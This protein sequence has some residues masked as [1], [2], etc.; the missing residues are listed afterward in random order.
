MRAIVCSWRT[1]PSCVLH[2]SPSGAL[3]GS[4]EQLSKR[5]KEGEGGRGDEYKLGDS[6]NAPE[7]VMIAT[8]SEDA[9]VKLW[10]AVDQRCIRTREEEMRERVLQTSCG[11][12]RGKRERD[13]REGRERDE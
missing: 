12:E 4:T 10:D 11:D 1:A 2:L 7:I 13:E 9:T 5:A 6:L 8:G 3:I